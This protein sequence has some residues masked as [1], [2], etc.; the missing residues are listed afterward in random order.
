MSSRFQK[1]KDLLFG[2]YLWFTN[3]VSCGV[4][5]AAGDVIQQQIEFYTGSSQ[6]GSSLDPERIG[7]HLTF[8]FLLILY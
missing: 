7:I 5:L 3:T 2:R 1:L 6:S 4:L 8:S